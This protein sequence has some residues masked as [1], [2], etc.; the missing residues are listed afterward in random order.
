MSYQYPP[1]PQD[2]AEMDIPH[3]GYLSSYATPSASSMEVRNKTAHPPPQPPNPAQDVHMPLVQRRDSVYKSSKLR[4]A[5]STP[6]VQMQGANDPENGH[7]A[8]SSNEKRRNKLGYHRTSVACDAAAR[9]D[10]QSQGHCRRRK[11]RCILQPADPGGRCMNC[12]RL[13]KECSFFPVDQQ[14][15]SL[16][17]AKQGARSSVGSK[18]TSA[19]SSPALTTGQPPDVGRHQLY[20]Q[21][22]AAQSLQ[23]MGPPGMQH[24]SADTYP[25][26]PEG[27]A[28]GSRGYEFGHGVSDWIATDASGGNSAKN[29]DD[30]NASWRTYPQASPVTPAFSPYTTHAVPGSTTWS[31][32]PGAGGMTAAAVGEAGS[33][34]EDVPW[35]SYAA[36]TTRSLS[37]GGGESAYSPVSGARTYDSRRISTTTSYAP[38]ISATTLTGGVAAVDS[39]VSLSAGAGPPPNYGTWSPHSYGGAY[40]RRA[41]AYGSVWYNESAAGTQE[42]SGGG[43]GGETMHHHAGALYYGGR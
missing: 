32:V 28:P 24:G 36:G 33:R 5:S 40:G 43:G 23:N 7:M 39:A 16:P 4:R 9:T 1:P 17:G 15:P 21:L 42:A 34:A 37:Y 27:S 10:P 6:N 38:S 35:S 13:K 2:G 26:T 11:I 8:L 14:P 31:A 25:V 18:I 29:M 12:I 41:D 20:P 22:N 30:L 3:A 19:S